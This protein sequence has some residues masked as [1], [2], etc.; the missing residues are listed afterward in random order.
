MLIERRCSGKGT[1]TDE[2]HLYNGKQN[3]LVNKIR[4]THTKSLRGRHNKMILGINKKPQKNRPKRF[5]AST[6]TVSDQYSV[7]SCIIED[8]MKKS[9]FY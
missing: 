4:I 9:S 7:L 3:N 1:H 6:G 8:L 2:N 5:S